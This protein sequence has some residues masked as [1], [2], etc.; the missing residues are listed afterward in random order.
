MSESM[1]NSGVLTA[2]SVDSILRNLANRQY[3]LRDYLLADY[4]LYVR[5]AEDNSEPHL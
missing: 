4:K 1:R 5:Y 2:E 3:Q